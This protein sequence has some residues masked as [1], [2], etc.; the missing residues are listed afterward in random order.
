MDSKIMGYCFRPAVI[1]VVSFPVDVS[2]DFV[3]ETVRDASMIP[4]L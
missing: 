1:G 4:I 3:H 2:F